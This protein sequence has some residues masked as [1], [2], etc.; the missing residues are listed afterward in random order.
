[1]N[2]ERDVRGHFI[3]LLFAC[4]L[5]SM[6][7]P[8]KMMADQQARMAAMKAKQPAQSSPGTFTQQGVP[9]AN[10]SVGFQNEELSR[11]MTLIHHR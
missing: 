11:I 3:S 6:P 9:A 8:A 7:D 5:I 1:M 10:E 2:A 4:E